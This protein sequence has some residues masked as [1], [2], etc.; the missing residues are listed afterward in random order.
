M[1]QEVHFS[2]F[3]RL[4]R[5]GRA[6]HSARDFSPL[7]RYARRRK[8][9][10]N[11]KTLHVDLFSGREK[12]G[13]RSLS[14]TNTIQKRLRVHWNVLAI[15]LDR[16]VTHTRYSVS[17]SKKNAATARLKTFDTRASSL[18]RYATVQIKYQAFL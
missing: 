4:I 18:S 7:Q 16:R 8:R 2:C 5:S 17:P 12:N 10:R 9:K 14:A 1:W 6:G 11:T 15:S 13:S 3:R